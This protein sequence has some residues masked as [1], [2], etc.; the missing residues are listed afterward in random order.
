MKAH[1]EDNIIVIAATGSGKTEGALMWIQDKKAF[2]TLPLRVSI[3]A[4]YERIKTQSSSSM[5]VSSGST[6][7]E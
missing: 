5:K 7:S 1:Q 6:Q 3:N 2:Y 4:I